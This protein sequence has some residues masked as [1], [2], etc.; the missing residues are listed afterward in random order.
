MAA[1]VRTA[2]LRY[3]NVLR[4]THVVIDL[5]IRCWRLTWGPA[6]RCTVV[7]V[8]LDSVFLHCRDLRGALSLPGGT[9]RPLSLPGSATTDDRESIARASRAGGWR[10]GPSVRAQPRSAVVRLRYSLIPNGLTEP[11][12]A[13]I[14]VVARSAC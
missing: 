4:R 10:P 13:G 2:S 5:T 11:T 7:T 14:G 3:T 12:E 9:F 1:L 8:A 6:H